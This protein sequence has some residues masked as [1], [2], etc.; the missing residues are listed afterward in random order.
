MNGTRKGQAEFIEIRESIEFHESLR[1]SWASGEFEGC[2]INLQTL[3]PR[4][5]CGGMYSKLGRGSVGAGNST[6]AFRKRGFDDPTFRIDI[7][8]GWFKLRFS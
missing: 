6:P 8:Y 2:L 7:H 1:V 3:D 5:K 4:L